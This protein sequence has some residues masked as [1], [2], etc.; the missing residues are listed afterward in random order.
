MSRKKTDDCSLQYLFQSA[1][2]R[3]KFFFTLNYRLVCEL[4]IVHV[5]LKKTYSSCV[6]F[7]ETSSKVLG[8]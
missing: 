4:S 7:L 2:E 6:E 8:S 3:G 5:D 1:L